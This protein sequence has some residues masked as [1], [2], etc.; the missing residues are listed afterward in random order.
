MGFCFCFLTTRRSVFELKGQVWVRCWTKRPCKGAEAAGGQEL[1]GRAGAGS[2][3][4]QPGPGWAHTALLLP[5]SLSRGPGSEHPRLRLGLGWPWSPWSRLG[6]CLV[7]RRRFRVPRS[8]FRPSKQP[9]PGAAGKSPLLRSR[10]LISLPALPPLAVLTRTCPRSRQRLRQ[11]DPEIIDKRSS[12]LE[13]GKLPATPA[14]FSLASIIFLDDSMFPTLAGR[15][16]GFLVTFLLLLLFYAL[17]VVKDSCKEQSGDAGE[18]MPVIIS[19]LHPA[20]RRAALGWILLR[21]L[22]SQVS[23]APPSRS[24][25]LQAQEFFIPTSRT[26]VSS[27]GPLLLQAVTLCRGIPVGRDTRPAGVGRSRTSLCRARTVLMA[28]QP[29]CSAR[30]QNPPLPAP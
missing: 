12:G 29:D 8:A 26:P 27:L 2:S 5:R 7:S 1:G 16:Q 20:P 18:Q 23:P 14:G 21:A 17:V 6:T 15:G 10:E 13:P 25:P 28:M 19:V 4:L 11:P 22:L 30:G 9:F 3:E 24:V